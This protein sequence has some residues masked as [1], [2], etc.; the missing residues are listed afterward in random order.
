[1]QRDIIS[2]INLVFSLSLM[3]DCYISFPSSHIHVIFGCF[4]HVMP[5]HK[6]NSPL[7]SRT[8]LVISLK[9]MSLH[10]FVKITE[11]YNKLSKLCFFPIKACNG[12]YS[13]QIQ[14]NCTNMDDQ[15]RVM[16]ELQG[17]VISMEI[18]FVGV[19]I[20]GAK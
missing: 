20:A 14:R 8:K 1:M 16:L 15:I 2:L 17:F 18:L 5:Q 7:P 4:C 11:Y 3:I 10:A 9:L 12:E 19:V 6:T 13:N